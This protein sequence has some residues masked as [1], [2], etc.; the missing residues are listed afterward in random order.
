MG[1]SDFDTSSSV[2]LNKNDL[3]EM[4]CRL[5]QLQHL[6]EACSAIA[7]VLSFLQ[8]NP[9]EKMDTTPPYPGKEI[10]DKIVTNTIG[11]FINK[12]GYITRG[13]I[14]M[15]EIIGDDIYENRANIMASI[16][17]A[18]RIGSA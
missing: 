12:R 10:V 8:N 16:E 2:T 5:D 6:S 3:D 13:L 7:A 14:S 11:D 15:I 9:L 17:E 18:Q 4:I 1:N